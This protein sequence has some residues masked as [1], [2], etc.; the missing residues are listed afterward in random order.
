LIAASSVDIFERAAQVGILERADAD[1][2]IGARRR[3]HRVQGILRLAMTRTTGEE[4]LPAALRDLMV[5]ISDARDFDSLRSNLVA[6]QEF[7]EASFERLIATH[8][9][10]EVESA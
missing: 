2:L 1:G 8:A 10:K 6:G 9:K 5:Q 4:E 7:V 3:M